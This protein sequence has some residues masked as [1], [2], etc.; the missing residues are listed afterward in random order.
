MRHIA[1]Q[2]RDTP[3]FLNKLAAKPKSALLPNY[4]RGG[5]FPFCLLVKYRASFID[6]RLEPSEYLF[7]RNTL[8]PAI[9]DFT[10]PPLNFPQPLRVHL[11]IGGAIQLLPKNTQQR[12]LIR[13][14]KLADFLFNCCERSGHIRQLTSGSSRAQRP[15]KC[16]L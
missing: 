13:N 14:A 16:D 7:S 6:E 15:L 11:G 12:F 5:N 2:S 9:V 1:K 8:N 10:T 3:D 4:Q